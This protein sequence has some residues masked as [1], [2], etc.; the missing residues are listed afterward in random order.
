MKTGDTIKFDF[1]VDQTFRGQTNREALCSGLDVALCFSD[2][3][4]EKGEY[5]ITLTKL[6]PLR[7]TSNLEVSK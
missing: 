3:S 6:Q 4:I 1:T 7:E 5:E 2:I